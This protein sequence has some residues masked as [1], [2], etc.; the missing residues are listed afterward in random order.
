MIVIIEVAF[1]CFAVVAAELRDTF[2]ALRT[3]YGH[4]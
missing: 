2:A 3:T 1:I 4:K